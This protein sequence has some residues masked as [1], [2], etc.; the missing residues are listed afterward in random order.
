MRSHRAFTLIELLVVIGIIAILAGLLLPALAQAKGKAKQ[1]QCLNNLKQIGLGYIL[2]RSDNNDR[3]C[4]QRSC[5]DTPADPFGL[6]APVPSGT[7]AG[8]PAPT[9]PN[10]TW[11]APYDP[12]QV[13]NG[14]P[15][16][17][18]KAGLL[19]PYVFAT[20]LFKCPS[21]PQWQSG[22]GMN[23]CTGGPVGQPESFITQPAQRLAIWDHMRSP[24]C[25]D[26]TTPTPP[27]T[28]WYP[29]T[30]AAAATHY[31]RRHHLAFQGLFVDGHVALV[32][33]EELTPKFFREP[34][35][36]PAIAAYP[37]E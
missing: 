32:R 4:P 1:T 19:F 8:V 5:P 30:N 25:A 18:Y 20:N 10:E 16:A 2:Y 6:S 11:W 26:S 33:P 34:G 23:Y 14:V 35:T 13:P 36:G 28:P 22:Y 15:G 29:F 9:G 31:P 27:R 12:T 21:D 17:G 37:G 7:S 3:Y 24:G